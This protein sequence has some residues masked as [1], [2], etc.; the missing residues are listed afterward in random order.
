MRDMFC[1]MNENVVDEDMII[2]EFKYLELNGFPPL[3]HV[4]EESKKIF[5]RPCYDALAEL[6]IGN[7]YN[8]IHRNA[9]ILIS[10]NP[11]IG[12]SRFYIYFMYKLI[13]GNL[14]PKKKIIINSL[15]IH[16]L[17]KNDS[18]TFIILTDDEISS[19]MKEWNVV[20]LIDGNSSSLDGWHGISI[21]FASPSTEGL[22]D[23]FKLHTIT[24]YLPI[25]SE[26]ELNICNELISLVNPDILKDNFDYFGGIP[27]FVLEKDIRA[28]CALK[29]KINVVINSENKMDII[30]LIKSGNIL[31]SRYSHLLLHMNTE[32]N[33][34]FMNYYLDFASNTIS[35]FI[36][37]QLIV[38]TYDKITEFFI[39]NCNESS[40]AVLRGKIFE[41]LFHRSFDKSNNI[42]IKILGRSLH[43]DRSL[44]IFVDKNHELI[45][46]SE[47]SELNLIK[48][49]KIYYR[50]IS[51]SFGAIDSLYWNGENLYLFQVTIA[52]NHTI[53]YG[54]VFELMKWCKKNKINE[55]NIFIIFIVPGLLKANYKLQK[56]VSKGKTVVKV[57]NTIKNI[58]QFVAEYI[59]I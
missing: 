30:N 53:N 15:N 17:W 21:L 1:T 7:I 40:T 20:R 27:R 52:P 44:E 24:Y 32:K 45:R 39:V 42:N 12:K 58:K 25:W 47:F 56:Y 59:R 8:G 57:A 9:N 31:S 4:D 37:N 43:D 2:A 33:S 41:Q 19:Y 16:Y 38:Q 49:K 22:K 11:G 29:R 36:F 14:D 6:L 13:K 18:K 50:P 23:F 54:T 26:Y 46:F 5:I 34:D 28:I 10:G 35:D 3:I 48:S 51:K 55:F